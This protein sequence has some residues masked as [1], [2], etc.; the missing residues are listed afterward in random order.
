M[1]KHSKTRSFI[2]R[3]KAW[4]GR[5]KT[6]RR[7]RNPEPMHILISGSL[8]E[9]IR[10]VAEVE[11]ISEEKAAVLILDRG[12]SDYIIEKFDE[13]SET[14]RQNKEMNLPWKPRATQLERAL[15]KFREERGT[16]GKK[17]T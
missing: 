9:K 2:K 14:E 3:I 12:F 17:S 16:N 4:L 1:K 13:Q 10:L 7:I 6:K 8:A 5:S 15:K 11:R